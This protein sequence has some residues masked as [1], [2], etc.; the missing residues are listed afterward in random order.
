MEVKTKAGK[1]VFDVWMKEESDLVQAAAAAY[2]EHVCMEQFVKAVGEHP[3]SL[4]AICCLYA[5]TRLDADL[6]FFLTRRLIN[7]NLVSFL[8][9]LRAYHSF[10]SCGPRY[11]L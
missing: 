10:M 4:H 6:S 9:N 7:T 5:V 1:T 11:L 2:G 8:Q 3:R